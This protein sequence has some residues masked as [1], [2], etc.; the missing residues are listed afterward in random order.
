M[1][2][3]RN[4]V[5]PSQIQIFTC[6]DPPPEG[7]KIIEETCKIHMAPLIRRTCNG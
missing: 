5:V 6:L 4:N 3:I 2:V 7:R 1:G